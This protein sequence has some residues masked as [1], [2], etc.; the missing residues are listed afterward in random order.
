MIQ[1]YTRLQPEP[2]FI[3]TKEIFKYSQLHTENLSD[4]LF[5]QKS[6]CSNENQHYML[7]SFL[8]LFWN[9][10]FKF[11]FFADLKVP[12]KYS[13][14]DITSNNNNQLK[15]TKQRYITNLI[16]F[17]VYNKMVVCIV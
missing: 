13:I 11:Q 4:M 12:C 8:K 9:H 1:Y 5:Y 3:Q 15:P 10:R 6:I 16:V 17:N 14:D 2:F 7:L